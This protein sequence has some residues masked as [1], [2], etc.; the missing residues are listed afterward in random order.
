MPLVAVKGVRRMLFQ[1][2]RTPLDLP[3]GVR[4]PE[5]LKNY[6]LGRRFFLLGFEDEVNGYAGILDPNDEVRRHLTQVEYK[7]YVSG[8]KA[9]QEWKLI[10]RSNKRRRIRT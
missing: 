4:V 10:E 5:Y 2:I 9:A 3:R 7:A 6:M 1:E 8:R